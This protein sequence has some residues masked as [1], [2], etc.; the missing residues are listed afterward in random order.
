MTADDIL[1]ALVAGAG[2][3]I[4]ATELAMS[5]GDRRCDFWTISPNGSA[6]FKAVAYEIKISRADFRRD[7]A[8]KQREARLYSDQFY[9][10]TP[11]G[12]VRREE[13][14]EWAGLIEFDGTLLKRV[15]NAP[16]RDKDGPTWQFVVSLIRNSGKVN[17]DTDL[18]KI[19]LRTA[20]RQVRA[21]HD[22]LRKEGL[23]PWRFGIN[24]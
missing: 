5:G 22:A 11:A 1:A 6:G 18:L 9:Y 3:A 21:A 2:D 14:P 8:F 23:E 12:L 13:V 16:L 20:E 10:V 19:R 15:V 17:R 24:L 4:F 7:H